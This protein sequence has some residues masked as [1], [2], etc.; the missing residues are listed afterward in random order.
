M[1]RDRLAPCQHYVAFGE[2]T[3]GKKASQK[4]LCQTCSKYEA[5]KGFRAP[6]NRKTEAKRQWAE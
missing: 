6:L 2:C 1:A 4:G 3:K 5:R